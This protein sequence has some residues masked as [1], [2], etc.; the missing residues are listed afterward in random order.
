MK[1]DS[2]TR[3]RRGKIAELEVATACIKSGLS[4][5]M[6]LVDDEH[7]DMVVRLGGGKHYDIQ[8]KSC[9]GY[10]RIIGIPWQFIMDKAASN[11]I[12]VL[13]YRF[14]NRPSEFYYL[15][16]KDLRNNKDF[17]SKNTQSN[18]GDLIFNKTQRNQYQNQN[19]EELTKYLKSLCKSG[20]D[21]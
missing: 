8:V 2:G 7:V 3:L 12:L 21:I 20:P 11:Y 5:F 18:W 19:I 6:P 4:V 16:I 13:A 10:N 15:T 17:R 14:N 1:N 9:L